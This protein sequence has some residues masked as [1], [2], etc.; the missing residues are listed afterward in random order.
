VFGIGQR[1]KFWAEQSGI[2]AISTAVRPVISLG[3]HRF[4]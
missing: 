1:S 4:R 2:S 3:D